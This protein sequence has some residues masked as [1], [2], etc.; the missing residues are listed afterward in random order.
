[1]LPLRSVQQLGLFVTDISLVVANFI[2][3]FLS[4]VFAQYL[5]LYADLPHDVPSLP[6]FGPEVSLFALHSFSL[7]MIVFR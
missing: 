2:A 3:I 6:S 1:M 5:D 7:L 4:I